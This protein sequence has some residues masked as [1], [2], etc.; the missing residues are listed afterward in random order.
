MS[1]RDLV[2]M[3]SQRLRDYT[4][5]PFEVF[6]VL[7]TA[8]PFFVLA[9]FYPALPDRVPVFMKLN[10]EVA[11]WAEKSVMSVFR[12]PL[13]AVD[14]QLV[15]LLVK[16]GIVH[17]ARTLGREADLEYQRQYVGLHTGLWD[18]FR[19]LVAVKMSAASLDTVFLS[20]EKFRF[21]ARPAFVITAVA[22]ALSIVGAVFYLYRL[23][24]LK[25]RF[26]AR[27]TGT[28]GEEPI[29]SRHVYGRVLYFNPSDSALFVRKYA[30]NF[31]NKWTWVFIACLVAY[32]LLVF[33]T[34][35][36]IP[37]NTTRGYGW[38]SLRVSR[39]S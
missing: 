33:S 17:S 6:V 23:L 14:T 29:D 34:F 21:L 32:P 9:Y 22:A 4:N 37:H 31:A 2:I 11:V 25:R 19:C 36:A 10:G 35:K 1:E 3:K 8:L 12:M 39:S 5:V 16:Y 13:M 26:K 7:C 38:Y 15:C 28:A 18:W 24:A 30:F 27:I 20:L